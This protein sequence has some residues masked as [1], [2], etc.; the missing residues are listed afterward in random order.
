MGGFMGNPRSGKACL[1]DW[2]VLACRYLR[3]SVTLDREL[4]GSSSVILG[5]RQFALFPVSVDKHYLDNSWKKPLLP[6]FW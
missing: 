5:I 1:V 4:T 3:T 6:R 2:L